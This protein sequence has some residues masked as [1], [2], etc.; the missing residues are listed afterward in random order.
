MKRRVSKYD[1]DGLAA[2]YIELKDRNPYFAPDRR[3]LRALLAEIDLE[4]EA[5]SMSPVE[6]L[7][8]L[9]CG[10]GY[11]AR[12]FKK[13]AA[14]KGKPLRVVGVD[15]STTMIEE[16][17]AVERSEKAGI[18]YVV[19]DVNSS[20]TV[21]NAG[22]PFDVCSAS[23]LINYFQTEESLVGVLKSVA[24][25]LKPSGKFIGL[26]V[27]PDC[28][29]HEPREF[30]H[31][32]GVCV[33]DFGGEKPRDGSMINVFIS[34]WDG[35]KDHI[36]LDVVYWSAEAYERAF[37]KAGMKVRWVKLEPGS[38]ERPVP[39]EDNT[40]WNKRQAIAFIAERL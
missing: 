11:Y 29:L 38:D 22:G 3:A 28:N 30:L 35:T 13:D 14:S 40:V 8:D 15:I 2:R 34:M 32:Y 37:E 36:T 24:A 20:D 33:T 10:N 9:A 25:L 6:D 26:T 39:T 4:R 17:R 12:L 31:R 21:T 16:A 7:A 19:G 27:N 23:F 18:T 1:E 5:A